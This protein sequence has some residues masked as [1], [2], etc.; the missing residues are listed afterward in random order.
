DRER[1]GWLTLG[2][3]EGV[4]DAQAAVSREFPGVGV[5]VVEVPF[6]LQELMDLHGRIREVLLEETEH[7]ASSISVHNGVVEMNVAILTYEI[8]QLMGDHFVGEPIC[9]VGCEPSDYPEPG[10]Q[11]L[12]GDGWRLLVHDPE[13]GWSYRTGIATDPESQRAMCAEVGLQ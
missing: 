8:R 10:P 2:F 7:I 9:L 11:R 5:V 1:N 13:V 12:E 3:T 6:T 4:A